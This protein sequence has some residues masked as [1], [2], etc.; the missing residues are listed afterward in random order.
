MAQEYAMK[1]REGTVPVSDLL[2]DTESWKSNT[3]EDTTLV[4]YDTDSDGEEEEM[5]ICES[6]GPTLRHSE[7][8]QEILGHTVSLLLSIFDPQF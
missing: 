4:N 2:S 6:D 8:C 7:S 3:E 1:Y 5:V